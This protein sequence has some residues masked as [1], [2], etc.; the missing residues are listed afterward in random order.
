MADKPKDQKF[1]FPMPETLAYP[2]QKVMINYE[3]EDLE[4]HRLFSNEALAKRESM[5]QADLTR[6]SAHLSADEVSDFYADNADVHGEVF[7]RLQVNSQLVLACSLFEHQ[8]YSLCDGI[9]RR[10]NLP[11]FVSRKSGGTLGEAKKYL[12]H[13]GVKGLFDLKIWSDVQTIFKVRNAVVHNNLELRNDEDLDKDLLKKL[14]S[15]P[16]LKHKLYLDLDKEPYL[17]EFSLSDAYLQDA[18]AKLKTMI[19]AVAD[20]RLYP[21]ADADN[22]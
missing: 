11:T 17:Y 21:D 1:K 9:K 13:A 7:E 18:F 5:V 8:L 16:N 6:R 15:D 22:S 20:Y 14:M 10:S 2:V 19:F 3:Y 12:T 4:L